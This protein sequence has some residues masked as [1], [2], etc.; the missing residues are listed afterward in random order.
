MKEHESVQAVKSKPKP[1]CQRFESG[2]GQSSVKQNTKGS[3][4]SSYKDCDFSA[5]KASMG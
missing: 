1:A 3:G 2:S 4:Q 5:K